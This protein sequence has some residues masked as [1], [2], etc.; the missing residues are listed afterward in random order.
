M[1][2][3]ATSG[4]KV[5]RYENLTRMPGALT[6]FAFEIVFNQPVSELF[7]GSYQAIRLAV[8][9][10]AR[11]MATQLNARLDPHNKRTLRKLELLSAIVEPKPIS[12]RRS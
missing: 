10:R 1:L 7:A 6:I 9:K 8:Q 4:T 11:R 3:G 12:A 5:S 2:L